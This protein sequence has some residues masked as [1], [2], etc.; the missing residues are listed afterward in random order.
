MVRFRTNGNCSTLSY[1]F[2]IEAKNLLWCD[3]NDNDIF[4]PILIFNAV[5]RKW[6]FNG[7]EKCYCATTTL[8]TTS[9]F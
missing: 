2:N 6:E 8:I 1:P 3:Q 9:Q 4:K 7:G 5:L